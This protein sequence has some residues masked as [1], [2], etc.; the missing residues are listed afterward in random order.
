MPILPRHTPRTI[1]RPATTSPPTPSSPLNHDKAS[2]LPRPNSSMSS[3][4]VYLT[5]IAYGYPPSTPSILRP[6][7]TL[8]LSPSSLHDG[9][10]HLGEW[11]ESGQGGKVGCFQKREACRVSG[12]WL[13]S[14]E[15]GG[16]RCSWT[17]RIERASILLSATAHPHRDIRVRPHVQ[18][19]L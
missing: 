2:F 9:V 18:R 17:S 12:C 14:F 10:Q 11:Y 16:R 7:G 15:G 19:H 13:W 8:S 3:R 6:R 5:P 1:G 4:N